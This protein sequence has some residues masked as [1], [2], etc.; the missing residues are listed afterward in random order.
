LFTVFT[1]A[2]V[3]ILFEGLKNK[4]PFDS[5]Q[6]RLELLQKINQALNRPL[7]AFKD[8]IDKRPGIKIYEFEKPGA[9]DAFFEVV[10]WYIETLRVHWNK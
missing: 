10:K 5:E 7:D 3:E 1:Y 9:I 4:S 6:K 8:K 2:S